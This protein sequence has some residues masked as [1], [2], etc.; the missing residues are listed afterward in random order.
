[1]ILRKPWSG[2]EGIRERMHS[3]GTWDAAGMGALPTMTGRKRR[4]D[5][6]RVVRNRINHGKKVA[7][8]SERENK[9][10]GVGG[11]RHGWCTTF[12]RSLE[13]P[14]RHLTDSRQE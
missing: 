13:C 4:Y 2:G 5:M 9:K 1:M 14:R 8:S 7:N 3:E 12:C 11:G 6:M 10:D